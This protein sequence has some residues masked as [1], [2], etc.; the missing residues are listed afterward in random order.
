MMFVIVPLNWERRC[1]EAESLPE[2][3]STRLEAQLV[4]IE[5]YRVELQRMEFSLD[6]MQSNIQWLDSEV[7]EAIGDK[8]QCD[9]EGR[10]YRL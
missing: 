4:D 5:L 8:W 3:T 9:E 7:F 2:D 10:A 1:H 6:K